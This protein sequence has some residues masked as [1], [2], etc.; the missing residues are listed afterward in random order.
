MARRTIA[1]MILLAL[2]GT[3]LGIPATVQA[4]EEMPIC[5]GIHGDSHLKSRSN[6]MTG[7]V[8]GITIVIDFP[9]VEDILDLGDIEAFLNQPGYSGHDNNGSVRD[10][11]YDVSG[12]ALIYTNTLAPEAFSAPNTYEHYRNQPYSAM[13]DLATAALEWLR[14]DIGFDFSGYDANGD[15]IVDAINFLTEAGYVPGRALHPHFSNGIDVVV[16]E[17]LI[18]HFQTTNLG[19]A[20]RLSVFCHEN[21]HQLC[22]WPDL[23]NAYG[24]SGLIGRLGLM[25]SYP[26]PTNPQEPYGYHK[27][28]AGW[29]TPQLLDMSGL[30]LDIASAVNQTCKI[31]HPDLA[32]TDEFYILE[33]RQAAGRDEHIQESGL[34]V[35][36]IGSQESGDANLIV[37]QADNDDD[38]YTYG[39][40]FNAPDHPDFDYSTTPA[41]YWGDG[42]FCRFAL[43]D[44]SEPSS[45]MSFTFRLVP[46]VAARVEPMPALLNA[47][48]T[49]TGPGDFTSSGEGVVDLVLPTEGWYFVHFEEVPYWPAPNPTRVVRDLL[50]PPFPRVTVFG[51][52]YPSPFGVFDNGDIANDTGGTATCVIDYSGV[53]RDDI[54]AAN[55]SRNQLLINDGQGGFNDVAPAVLAEA[56]GVKQ[57]AWADYDGDG[58]LDVFLVRADGEHKL[59]RRAGKRIIDVTANSPD[60]LAITEAS[61]ASWA[62]VDRDGFMD[63]FIV[64]NGSDNQLFMGAADGVFTE[65]DVGQAAFGNHALYAA[66]GDFN[67]DG[68]TDVFRTTSQIAA[69]GLSVNNGGVFGGYSHNIRDSWDGRWGDLN[70]DGLLDLVTSGLYFPLYI[71][72]QQSNGSFELTTLSIFGTSGISSLNLADFNND[73]MLDIFLGRPSRDDLLIINEGE[74]VPGSGGNPSRLLATAVPLA[75]TESLGATAATS[76]LD[77]A[78]DGSM[79]VM[80]VREDDSNYI[81]QNAL[82][83][84]GNWLR[85]KLV[86]TVSN[87][88]AMGA[89]VTVQTSDGNSQIREVTGGG[90]VG[91]D[92]C[93]LH[94]GL[95]D[96]TSVQVLTVRWAPGESTTL[97]VNVDANQTL[98]ITQGGSSRK[99]AEKPVETKF[100]TGVYPNPFNPSTSIAFTLAEPSHVLVEIYSIDGRRVT[101]LQNGV[102]DAGSHSLVWQG[103]DDAGQRVGSGLYFCRIKAGDRITTHKMNLVK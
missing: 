73:G 22:G 5:G 46:T 52:T 97:A 13:D 34:A 56:G 18:D 78:A 40:L 33:N 36:H 23:Y 47:P 7:D 17:L 30:T 61:A 14:D 11:F 72:I 84:D 95:G 67:D 16:G 26:H 38:L 92:P 80:V 2:G 65:G 25:G 88:S 55:G 32:I 74:I 93:L 15:G 87:T 68:Y 29:S 94:F 85:V 83:S 71:Y 10:Y 102:M 49:M 82:G 96:N 98:V 75:L 42:T 28:L 6:P 66:W 3:T 70:N 41:P 100:V 57:A 50:H 79:D 39:N 63:L 60:L 45:L 31:P 64:R 4:A 103:S 21:G 1:A 59:L 99:Q 35:Y 9:D 12:G 27:I 62:D 43:R 76:I 19:S 8:V 81:L 54:F 91:Q 89:R 90:S 86:P 37:V 24:S 77:H 53:G 44:I 20:P 69:N 101:G 58:Q 48:W 51:T